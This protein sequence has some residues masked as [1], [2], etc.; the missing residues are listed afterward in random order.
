M[1][2]ATRLVGAGVP[3]LVHSLCRALDRPVPS[4]LSSADLT[5]VSYPHGSRILLEKELEVP[6]G[7]ALSE[8]W[9]P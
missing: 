3:S 8:G 5:H 2:V 9:S 7:R 4:R 1:P 6:Q